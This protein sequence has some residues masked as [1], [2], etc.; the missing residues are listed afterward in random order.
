MVDTTQWCRGIVGWVTTIGDNAMVG[1]LANPK[2]KDEHLL[3]G[4]SIT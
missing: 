3:T 4:V 2:D 1:D